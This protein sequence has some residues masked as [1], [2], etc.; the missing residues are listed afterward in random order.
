MGDNC[1]DANISKEVKNF[2]EGVYD[3]G[4]K[5]IGMFS[6]FIKSSRTIVWNGAV[7]FFEKN[8]YK[9]GTYSVARLVSQ[10]SKGK[11]FG[12]CGGGETVQVLKKLDLLNDIDLVST[13]GGA[14]L[15]YLSGKKLPGIESLKKTD[16][17]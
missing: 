4:P 3:I 8:N 15:E 5:T 10:K 7:G 11:T 6:R 13:G 17:N 1:T 12:V 9:Y 2:K 16:K 14:M